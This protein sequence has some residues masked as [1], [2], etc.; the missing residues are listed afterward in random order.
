M[1]TRGTR[2]TDMA[3][4][5]I[6][7]DEGI[8]EQTVEAIELIK[9]SKIPVIVAINKCDKY[10][11]D[12]KKARMQLL[13]HGIVLEEFGGNVQAV[14]ISALKKESLDD[15]ETSIL[16]QAESVNLRADPKGKAEGF[17]VESSMDKGKGP[18]AT[19]LV[20]SGTLRV[21]DIFVAG[22]AWGKVRSLY[23]SDG[24]VV[25]EAGP[26]ST[27]EIVGFKSVPEPGDE[28]YVVDS[29]KK[30]RLSADRRALF[31]K[32]RKAVEEQRARRAAATAE[33]EEGEEGETEKPKIKEVPVI[34]KADA[35]GS[36]Q[37]LEGSFLGLPR[38]EIILKVIKSGVGELQESDIT[39]AQTAK[40]FAVAFN[41][42][43][44][45]KILQEA[46]QLG[47][48]LL[49]DNVIYNILDGV[50]AHLSS[51]LPPS[52]ET[53]IVGTAE[54]AQVFK[55]NL[56]RKEVIEVAGCKIT[57]G[58][59]H[60]S[61]TVKLVRDGEVL[62]E[63]KIASLKHHKDDLTEAKS[64]TEC[65]INLEG[66]TDIKQGDILQSVKVRTVPRKM[67]E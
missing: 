55:F 40:G 18:V 37:A 7:A 14:N 57:S 62:F 30:A 63:G 4:L 6:A 59:I 64:G 23:D 35:A 29:D 19:I 65:G 16:V 60:R 67:E 58:S 46:K 5:V 36:I 17:I 56:T 28:I 38:D 33:A 13:E 50:K 12:P 48:A 1:R 10:N 47:V 31:I 24:K 45:P 21:N 54:V 61:A 27:V 2:M 66:W 3:I 8:K 20:Q 42:K 52:Y 43:T 51:F 32:N 34:I 44:P 53:D 11:T 15:L 41:V 9:V 39:L 49:Q 22:A 25:T 26:A